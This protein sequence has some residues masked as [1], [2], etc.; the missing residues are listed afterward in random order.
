MYDYIVTF[1]KYLSRA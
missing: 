1:E